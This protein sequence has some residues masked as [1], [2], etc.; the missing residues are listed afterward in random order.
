VKEVQNYQ[1]SMW[2]YLLKEKNRW[3]STKELTEM[4]IKVLKIP[5]ESKTDKVEIYRNILTIIR[6]T[7]LTHGLIVSKETTQPTGVGKLYYAK[8]FKLTSLGTHFLSLCVSDK[9]YL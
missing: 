4:V 1:N 8:N 9:N 7:L 2:L 3:I 6:D 5:I